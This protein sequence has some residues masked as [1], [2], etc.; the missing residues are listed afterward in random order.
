[1]TG[2]EIG[3]PLV[4]GTAVGIQAKGGM[5]GE[6]FSSVIGKGVDEGVGKAAEGIGKISD[7]N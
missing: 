7:N 6:A 4:E 1:M 3:A 5:I 2:A